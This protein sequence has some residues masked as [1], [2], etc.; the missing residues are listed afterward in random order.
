M[1]IRALFKDFSNFGE[2]SAR[3]VCVYVQMHVLTRK[4]GD[5]PEGKKGIFNK[6]NKLL[7]FWEW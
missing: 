5:S 4:N 3:S 6:Y 1:H 7:Q 2:I